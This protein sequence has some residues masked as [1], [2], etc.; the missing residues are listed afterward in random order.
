MAIT[1][2]REPSAAD[3]NEA[4]RLAEKILS[5]AIGTPGEDAIRHY[6]QRALWDCKGRRGSS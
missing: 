5:D 4:E 6:V 2:K 1:K 3:I